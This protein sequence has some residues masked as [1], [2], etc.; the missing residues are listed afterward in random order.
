MKRK[1]G[2]R[3]DGTC[4]WILGTEEFTSW[5]DASQGADPESPTPGIWWLHGNT[6]KG[7]STMSIFLA[8][9]LPTIFST[10]SGKTVAYFL[11]LGLRDPEDSHIDPK[12]ASLAARP[13]ASIASRIHITK[14]QRAQGE[15]IQIFRRPLGY[16]YE[17]RRRQ[18]DRSKVLYH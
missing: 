1:K 14:I 13:T 6:G 5:L 2:K 9:Q 16:V 11:R 7:K 12:R 10:T 18:E 15:G 8:E 3:A 17:Y 4:Q